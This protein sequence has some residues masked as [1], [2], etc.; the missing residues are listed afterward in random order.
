MVLYF[1]DCLQ[2]GW[3]LWREA[4]LDAVVCGAKEVMAQWLDVPAVKTGG[5]RLCP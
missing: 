4:S 1:G 3:L 2:K 5:S